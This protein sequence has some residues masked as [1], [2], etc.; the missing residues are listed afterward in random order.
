MSTGRRP[1]AGP[2][3]PFAVVDGRIAT[4]TGDA[5]V[6]DDI[7]HLLSTRTGERALRRAYGGGVHHRLQEPSDG[8][9]RSLLRHEV[10]QA[11]R[12]HL[13]GLRLVGPIRV[14]PAADGLVVALDYRL[15]PDGV[16]SHVEVRT[17]GGT[18]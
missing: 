1:L 18:P 14:G 7:R 6:A 17:S 10:E 5:K 11:L 16:V 15:D 4:S 9:L 3:F 13:P 8:T 2:A 12:E